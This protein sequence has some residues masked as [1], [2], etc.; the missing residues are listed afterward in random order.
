MEVH[1]CVLAQVVPYKLRTTVFSLNQAV[2]KSF[3]GIVA[4]YVGFLAERLQREVKEMYADRL[5]DEEIVS[6]DDADESAKNLFLAIGFPSF[7]SVVLIFGLYWTYSNDRDRARVESWVDQSLELNELET[8]SETS[9]ARRETQIEM[10][11]ASDE[12]LTIFEESGSQ[13]PPVSIEVLEARAASQK[14]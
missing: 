11:W 14:D 9:L 1:L 8:D 2:Q 12:D 3:Y 13:S 5:G 6:V 10:E 7:V 4:P